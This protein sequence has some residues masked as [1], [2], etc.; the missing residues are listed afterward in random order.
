MQENEFEKKL[1]QKMD[2]LQFQPTEEVWQKVQ[3]QVV[4]KKRRR[5][6][7]VFLFLLSGLIIAGLVFTNTPG[8]FTKKELVGT[9][10]IKI[11]KQNEEQANSTLVNDK[12][13]EKKSTDDKQLPVATATS[14]NDIKD[15]TMPV[16]GLPGNNNITKTH[17]IKAKTKASVKT[18]IV[19][20]VQDEMNDKEVDVAV[21]APSF[22]ETMKPTDTEKNKT[23]F[24][25]N[26]NDNT[27]AL[28]NAKQ[29]IEPVKKETTK[30]ENKP[31]KENKKVEKSN[32]QKWGLAV[33]LSGG[34]SSTGNSYLNNGLYAN[35]LSN[36]P[37]TGSNPGS[38]NIYKPSKTS[39]GFSFVAGIN[40][41]RHISK[42]SSIIA[43]LQYQLM[44]T[45]IKTGQATTL[46]AYADERFAYGT[47]KNYINHYHFISLPLSFSTQLFSIG[48]RAVC[49]DAGINFSR[50]LSTDALNFNA[51]QG[52][53]YKDESLFNKTLM[54][55]NAG[56]KFN[57]AGKDKAAFYIGTEFYYSLTPLASS[58]MYSEAHSNF[59][60]IRLQKNLKK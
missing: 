14:I 46:S 2:A 30:N 40:V 18:K 54:G 23:T 13:T 26:K 3:A 52:V 36:T 10:E 35:D 22:D 47:T 60:G 20:P 57:L 25:E 39:P 16:S 49:F 55:L 9:N 29:I 44:N 28:K 4:E 43:G 7:I 34:Q 8:L 31:T 6:G 33:T 45:S 32:Q 11:E 19:S 56:V 58:G 12:L 17:L 41:Y 51:V 37:G 21:T 42:H 38:G 27:V 50:L 59:I 24:T 53:Y 48:Q 1:Q 5:R 15:T